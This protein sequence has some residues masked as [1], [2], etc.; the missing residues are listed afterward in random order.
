MKL[1][2]RNI[3]SGTVKSVTKG[4]TTSHVV[5]EVAPGQTITAAITNQAVDDLGLA[6]G[7]SASAI[8]KASDV[9]IG[10]A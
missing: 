4:A 1:S 5:V 7:V 6:V 9:L 10:V 8:I 3:L 2:A